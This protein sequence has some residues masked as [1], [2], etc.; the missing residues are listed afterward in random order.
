MIKYRL[1][2]KLCI[3]G[4]DLSFNQLHSLP[5]ELQN[6]MELKSLNI[7][8]NL[9]T[10]VPAVVV[11]CTQL[12][13]LDISCNQI[14]SLPDDFGILSELHRLNLAHNLFKDTVCFQFF[15]ALKELDMSHNQ[16]QEVVWDGGIG[17]VMA[18]APWLEVIDFKGNPF[19]EETHRNLE[20]IVRLKILTD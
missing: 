2:V 20:S 5:S 10:D 1:I 14:Q 17:G 7:S 12:Q 9:F 3:A 11:M 8:N 18:S 16:I 4:L 6:L 19:K 15:P 13:Q